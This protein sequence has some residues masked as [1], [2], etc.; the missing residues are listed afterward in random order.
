MTPDS[1]R[2]LAEHAR[3]LL[4][5]SRNAKARMTQGGLEG[6]E[7]VEAPQFDDRSLEVIDRVSAGREIDE[8][9]AEHLEAIILPGLR[10]VFD[11]QN[12][13][14]ADLKGE[15]ATLNVARPRLTQAIR[16]IGRINLLNHPRLPYGGTGF[17][18]GPGLMLTN[19]HVA[20]I[21]TEGLGDSNLRS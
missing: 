14:F 4:E 19:R 5:R 13:T 8:G 2:A 3:K 20:G 15:W 12:D 10:P 18:V 1:K 17:L 11:I 6:L 21:F 9:S 16:A 7:A